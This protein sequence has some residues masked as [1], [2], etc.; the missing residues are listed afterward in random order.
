LLKSGNLWKA[1]AA[2]VLVVVLGRTFGFTSCTIPSSGMENCLYQGERVLVNKW[3]YGLRLPFPSLLGYKRLLPERV[4]RGDVVLFNNP[5]SAAKVPRLEQ[6]DIFISRCGGG[7]GDTLMLNR[8]MWPTNEPV[9]SPDSKA[10]YAYASAQDELVSA[11]MQSLGLNNELVGYTEKG[12]YIRSFS[13]YENYLLQ[14]KLEGRVNVYPLYTAQ[15]GKSLPFV[16]PAKGMR[17]NVYPW[18]ATLLCNTIVQHEGKR[19]EVK[20]DSLFVEGK[21]APAYTFSKDYYWMVSNDPVNLSDSRLFGFVPE[22]H[23]I[24]KA[25][26]I[27]F[28]FKWDRIFRKVQ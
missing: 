15:G 11:V 24:G 7:P 16:V 13:A 21:F 25:T 22:D 8:E 12:E 6:R 23:L 18:N 10:L 5:G 2:A 27:W 17:V 1:V 20:N 19:A 28:S 3:S 26:R 14:Q 9:L 4:K